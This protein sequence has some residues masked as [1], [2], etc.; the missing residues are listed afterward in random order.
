MPL[1]VRL[2]VQALLL[3]RRVT[4]RANRT[5]S[6]TVSSRSLLAF[7]AVIL[8][9]SMA[10]AGTPS[11]TA[12][13]AELETARAL[14]RDAVTLHRQDKLEEALARITAP[15]RMVRTPVI[16]LPLAKIEGKM[17]RSF[18]AYAGLP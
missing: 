5:R 9:P 1:R 13:E 4:Q 7:P 12:S 10:L 15:Y 18:G 6:M 8:A 11:G 16:A 2:R 3:N 14:Y 17:G